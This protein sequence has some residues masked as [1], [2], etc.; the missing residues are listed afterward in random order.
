VVLSTES[1]NKNTLFAFAF[2]QLRILLQC[3]RHMA[4]LLEQALVYTGSLIY[5]IASLV[6]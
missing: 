3:L 2:V 5:A 4:W 1:G 6:V